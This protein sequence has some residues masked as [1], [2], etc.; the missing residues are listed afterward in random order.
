MSLNGSIFSLDAWIAMA[1]SAM[2]EYGGF[3]SPYVDL[4]GLGMFALSDL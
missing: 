4:P 1:V 2:Y 3:S